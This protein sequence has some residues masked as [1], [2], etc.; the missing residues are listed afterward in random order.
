M[1]VSVA[2]LSQITQLGQHFPKHELGFDRAETPIQIVFQQWSII[3]LVL[4]DPFRMDET[5]PFRCEQND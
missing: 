4:F 5:G 2:K 1:I 3:G